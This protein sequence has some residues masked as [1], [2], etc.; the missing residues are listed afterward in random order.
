[1][2]SYCV[3]Q[4][5]KTEC[6]PNSETFVITKNCRNAMRC[7]CAECGITKFRFIS[8]GEMQG[9]GFDELIVK[10]LAAGAK[11]LYNLGK[12]GA[13][14]AIKSDYV[15]DKV[16]GIGKRYLN[17][18]V[19][20]LA[21]DLSKKISG[22]GRGRGLDIHKAIG[23]LPK[24]KAGWTLPGHK[25]TGPYNDL[26]RQVKWDRDTGQI[27]EIYDQPTGKTDAI[28]M[29]HDVDYSVCADKGGNVKSC[30][31]VA[32]K[33]MVQALD[34]IPWNE[35]Q[36]G[37]WLARNTINTKQKLGLG[38]KK[39][40]AKNLDTW[41]ALANELHKP[42]KRNFTKRRV[43][44]HNV[45]DIWCSDLV[46]MQKLSKWNRGY[47]YLLMVLDLFSKYGW[48][49]PLKT[50]T[51]LEVAK[52]F[53]SLLVK[54]KPKMLWVDKGKEYYNKNVLDLLAKDNIKVYSTEN[55]EKS[56]VCERWNRTIK[57][58]MY[59]RFTM[60]NNTVYVD[61]L[62][63]ILAS[64]N[65]SRHRSIGMTPIQARKPENYGKVY[66]N[67]Y[68]DLARDNRKPEFRVGDRVRI[69][70]YKRVTFDK[71]YT[72]N[73]TEEVFII[74]E[75]R[76]TNPITYKIKDLNGEVIKGTFYRE[77][78][79]KTDQEVYRIEKIIRKSK[80]KALVKWKGYPDEFNSW[81]PLKDLEK[82]I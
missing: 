33:K 14:R 20:S 1:M 5:K 45:D 6:V 76:F 49:V 36:W 72:P 73:W 60:Q 26:E 48:I 58:K 27:Y 15:K 68:G 50:K 42:I 75:I 66:F 71:G 44:A 77:E 80:G 12:R 38:V 43:I 3:R 11:G 24:P 17:R 39:K 41:E 8:K 54:N 19:D 65:N 46:D 67:L 7:I 35:R 16:K 59:K 18:A 62:P 47:K 78:L 9:S 74:D 34:A 30:K 70:K 40:N 23:K 56:S 52:A 53:E 22:R 21:D 25:Y 64:Y 13:S 2:L 61:I 32:D 31:N 55:E 28:A 29:Q 82:I 69:S 63:K 51:G 57:D 79:Q 81:V 37:H 10:G 4:R